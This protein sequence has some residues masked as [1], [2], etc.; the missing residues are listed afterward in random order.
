MLQILHI[1]IARF[2]LPV[3]WTDE[4][5]FLT[6]FMNEGVNEDS[7]FWFR[8]PRVYNTQ[9]GLHCSLSFLKKESWIMVRLCICHKNVEREEQ[10]RKVFFPY[11]N[12]LFWKGKLLSVI[13]YISCLSCWMCPSKCNSSFTSVCAIPFRNVTLLTQIYGVVLSCG[14]Y[15]VRILVSGDMY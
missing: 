9:K 7:E 12:I 4:V 15:V 2:V 8:S 5:L 6:S 3:T 14:T 1:W 13:C 11:K 10:V